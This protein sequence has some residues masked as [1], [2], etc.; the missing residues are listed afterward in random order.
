MAE[1]RKVETDVVELPDVSSD[2]DEYD[3]DDIFNY[4]PEDESIDDVASGL[5][6]DRPGPD[7]GEWLDERSREPILVTEE[8]SC[9]C[10]ACK[11]LF[12]QCQPLGQVN[13][14][15]LN[16]DAHVGAVSIYS[17]Y[18]RF[19]RSFDTLNEWQ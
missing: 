8:T 17:H 14:D 11:Y 5:D 16:S 13:L 3:Y 7:I 12:T 1:S 19:L 18:R 4:P 15:S 10:N 9:L 6:D 2:D